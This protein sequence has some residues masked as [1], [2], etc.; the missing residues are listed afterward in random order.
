MDK[1][2]LQNLFSSPQETEL[3]VR[4]ND[5]ST[6]EIHHQQFAPMEVK[7]FDI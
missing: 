4:Q 6:L 3:K 5:G 2:R 7:T 1:E